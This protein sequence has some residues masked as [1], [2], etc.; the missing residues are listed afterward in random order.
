M[1]DE[2]TGTDPVRIIDPDAFL[3]KAALLKSGS[4]FDFDLPLYFNFALLLEGIDAKLAGSSL[5]DVRASNPADQ[6]GVNH[7]HRAWASLGERL[8]RKFQRADAY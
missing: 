6:E 8:L 2:Q 5:K 7:I 4:Y 1:S 3:A